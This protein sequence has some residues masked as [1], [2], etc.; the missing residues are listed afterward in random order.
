MSDGKIDWGKADLE[1]MQHSAVNLFWQSRVLHEAC[2][3]LSDLS[4]SVTTINCADGWE[5]FRAQMSKFLGWEEQFGYALWTGNLNALN[6]GLSVYPFPANNR[7][8]LV[9]TGFH[10]LVRSDKC[11]S[12]IMLDLLETHSRDFLLFA[13]RLIILVQ[14]DDNRFDCPPI[15]GRSP[16]WNRL[17]WSDQNRGL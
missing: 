1:L 5:S 6:D 9:L 15:G 11:A 16:M 12:H 3:A 8:A 7:A 17:E 4:Y 2:H 14:T 13:K 10:A